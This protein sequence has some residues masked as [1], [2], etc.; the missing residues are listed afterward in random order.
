MSPSPVSRSAAWL[1]AGLFSGALLC[2]LP[3]E[4]AA[5][6]VE[7]F[8]NQPG[9]NV[10]PSTQVVPTNCVTSPD[11]TVTCDTKVKNPRSNTP[12]KPQYSPFKN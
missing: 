8:I 2:L 1:P 7:S 10:G 4:P 3:L 9:S 11:G 12:A 5:A 6:Q